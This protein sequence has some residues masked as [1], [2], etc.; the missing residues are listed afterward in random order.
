MD[1][2]HARCDGNAM[3][4]S[5]TLLLIRHAEKS[6]I[7]E[8]A[9]LSPSGDA[10]AH[11]Y[12]AFFRSLRIQGSRVLAP[13]WLIAAADSVHSMRSRLT[14]APLSQVLG[15]PVD[16]AVADHA[17]AELALRLLVDARYDNATTLVCWHHG[18]LLNFARALGVATA[19]L[20]SVWPDTEFGWLLC[21]L[22]DAAGALT[23]TRIDSQRLMFGDKDQAPLLH[24]EVDYPP[25]GTPL[26]RGDP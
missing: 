26:L 15:L 9:G 19:A 21:L 13:A 23:S 6:G 22:F 7:R 12:V 4:K 8:D 25:F 24:S 18:Q 3:P 2:W 10:R 20:P 1:F 17:F 16:T 14:L 11:A 5:A